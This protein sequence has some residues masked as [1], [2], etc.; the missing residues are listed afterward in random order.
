MYVCIVVSDKNWSGRSLVHTHDVELVGY[1]ICI[2]TGHWHTPHQRLSWLCEWRDPPAA[3]WMNGTRANDGKKL[4]IFIVSYFYSLQCN[5][6]MIRYLPLPYFCHI[7]I[8][9]QLTACIQPSLKHA[10]LPPVL[11]TY[12]RTYMF[13][14]CNYRYYHSRISDNERI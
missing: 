5:A 7:Q 8:C 4:N 11:R 6:F 1:L 14:P 3:S 12:I 13:H 10:P 9:M 2:R